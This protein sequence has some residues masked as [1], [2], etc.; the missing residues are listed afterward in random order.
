MTI[1]FCTDQQ[2]ICWFWFIFETKNSAISEP[3][4]SLCRRCEESWSVNQ[5]ETSGNVKAVLTNTF[6]AWV[7]NC[8]C[9][10]SIKNI[11]AKYSWRYRPVQCLEMFS[12]PIFQTCNC[13]DLRSYQKKWH[14]FLKNWKVI[15]CRNPYIFIN[16]LLV[17]KGSFVGIK[18]CCF[19]V[20]VCVCFTLR[21]VV[22]GKKRWFIKSQ[23]GHKM[24]LYI[25]VK[26]AFPIYSGQSNSSS[27]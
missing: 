4:S 18:K 27:Y 20:C 5:R 26:P 23:N 21:G 11:V 13:S 1:A 14:F 3:R 19:C 10:L 22:R 9:I 24:P 6:K 16:R 15:Y 2:S 12:H 7:L 17:H 8:L 25:L